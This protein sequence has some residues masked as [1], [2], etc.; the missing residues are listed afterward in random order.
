MKMKLCAAIL[1]LSMMAPFAVFAEDSGIQVEYHNDTGMMHVSGTLPNDA[2][3]SWVTIRVLNAA[4]DKTV[5][6]TQVI[7][8]NDAFEMQMAFDVDLNYD[9]NEPL[10]YIE[11]NYQHDDSGHL[12]QETKYTFDEATKRWKD[13]ADAKSS[14]D[15]L[16]ILNGLDMNALCTEISLPSI[17]YGDLEELSQSIYKKLEQT[18]PSTVDDVK[19]LMKESLIFAE[20]KL[21]GMESVTRFVELENQGISS[22]LSLKKEDEAYKIYQNSSAKVKTAFDKEMCKSFQNGTEFKSEFEYLL[23]LS[24]LKNA[25]IRTEITYIL[26]QCGEDVLGDTFTNSKYTTLSGQKLNS[27]AD[28]LKK[29]A[30]SVSSREELISQFKLALQELE[31]Q[32]SDNKHTGGGGGGGS[33]SSSGKNSAISVIPPAAGTKT[34]ATITDLFE[35][36]DSVPWAKES[37]NALAKKGIVSGKE[38]YLFAPKDDVTREEFVKLLV[39]AL[40]IDCSG[41]DCDFDDLTKEHWAYSYI[42]GAYQNNLIKGV[43]DVFFGIGSKITREDM[44]VI[45][46]RAL[47]SKGL[48]QKSEPHSFADSGDIASYAADAV[49]I[50]AAMGIMNG[51]GDNQFLPKAYA[52]RAEAAKIIY[53]MMTLVEAE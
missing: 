18:P 14:S 4:K 38:K 8:E 17:E 48:I 7:A 30:A 40:K 25:E 27:F 43:S 39:S 51:V 46:Y 32:D 36:L 20:I 11:V 21:K 41:I 9:P 26:E 3:D 35:D 42:A 44:A 2:D 16:T 53:D 6:L 37:I 23:M 1:S 29:R 47:E 12:M 19:K 52:T 15:V 28:I 49:G 5:Y 10:Y 31:Q 24:T 34:D 50:I 45:V 22:I 33:S 13:I